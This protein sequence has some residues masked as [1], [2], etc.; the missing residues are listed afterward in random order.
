MEEC[1]HDTNKCYVIAIAKQCDFSIEK[2]EVHS[3][4]ILAAC[5]NTS[6]K[7]HIDRVHQ[8]VNKRKM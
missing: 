6:T 2:I 5:T 1:E 8:K 3:T 4:A 7:N